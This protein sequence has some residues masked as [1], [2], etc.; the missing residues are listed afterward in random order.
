MASVLWLVWVF[1]AQT[2]MIAINLL[3]AA[4]LLLAAAGWIYGRWCTPLKKKTTRLVGL[5]AA[6]ICLTAGVYA[7]TLAASPAAEAAGNARSGTEMALADGWEP[8]SAERVAE[9]R[10]KGIPVFIDFT[11]KWCLICQANHLVLS[12][13]ENSKLFD[14]LGVVKMKADW[15]KKD[16]AITEALRQ[17]GRNSVPLYVL[18]TPHTDA[19]PHILPQVLT[20]DT[21]QAELKKL[22]QSL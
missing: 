22:E 14:K 16:K 2:N 4:F 8:F 21:V 3:L 20:S 1:S 9:L 11:A 18:Y 19:K 12:K 17:F 6:L 10:Q 13:A 5:C 15:T 7:V